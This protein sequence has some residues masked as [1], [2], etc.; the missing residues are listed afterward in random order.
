VVAVVVV[1]VLEEVLP[2]EAVRVVFAQ[3]QVWP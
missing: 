1:L 2:Q 3:E